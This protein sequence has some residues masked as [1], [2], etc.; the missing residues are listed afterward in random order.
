M[1]VPGRTRVATTR[2]E[3]RIAASADT[4]W[5]VIAQPQSI[6]HWFPGVDSCTVDGA[7]RVIR[8]ANGMEMPEDIL[9]IDAQL[10]RFQYRITAP[11]YRHHLGT[12]DVISLGEIEALCVYSTM[13]EPDIFALLIGGGTYRAL[14]E[15]ERQ[16]LARQEAV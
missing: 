12:I 6:P 11:I 14:F 7:R 2:F 15:I 3:R 13:A 1:T 4:V 16:A 8:L 9:T 5:S 10:R